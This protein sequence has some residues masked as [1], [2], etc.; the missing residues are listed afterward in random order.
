MLFDIMPTTLR[1]VFWNA[2]STSRLPSIVSYKL[3]WRSPW[4]SRTVSEYGPLWHH[5][6]MIVR[7]QCIGDATC[8]EHRLLVGSLFL[9]FIKDAHVTLTWVKLE[10]DWITFVIYNL[11][12]TCGVQLGPMIFRRRLNSLTIDVSEACG[13]CLP[14]VLHVL[15]HIKC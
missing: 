5:C 3:V 6:P 15:I 2:P 7:I 14:I 12:L 11:E 9:F 4:D 10:S 1:A 13:L 8:H